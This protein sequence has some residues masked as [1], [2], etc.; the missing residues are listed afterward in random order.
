MKNRLCSRALL[1]LVV[2]ASAGGAL[3]GCGADGLDPQATAVTPSSGELGW[4]SPGTYHRH[5]INRGAKLHTANGIY[6]GPT[7]NIYVASVVERAITELDPRSGRILSQLGPEQGVETPDDLVFGPDGSLYWTAFLTGEVGRLDAAGVKTTVANLGLGVN[8]ITINGDGTKLYVSRVFLGDELW[9]LDLTGMA[10]PRLV[11]SALGG[12]NGMDM[13][14]DGYL[15]GPLWFP[16]MVARVD[17]ATGEVTVIAD[18]FET[19]AAVKFDSRGRLHVVD[20]EGGAVWRVDVATGARELVATVRIGVDNLAFDARDRLYLSNAYDGSVV[21]LLPSGRARRL[22]RGGLAT[23]GGI[24]VARHDGALR[25]F[26]SDTFT[27]RELQPWTGRELDTL[28]GVLGRPGL[29]TPLSAGSIGDDVVVTSWFAHTVQVWDPDTGVFLTTRTD[30]PVPVF[31]T[32]FDG[33]LVVSELSSHCV[34]RIP[35]GSDGKEALACNL[36]VPAGLAGQEGELFVTEWA[37]GSVLELVDGGVTLSP[38][39][40]VVTGLQ[41]PEGIALTPAGKLVVVETGS[42]RL[43]EVD[44]DTG[45]ITVIAEELGVALPAAAGYPPTWIFNGVAVDSCGVIYVTE[46]HASAVTQLVPPPSLDFLLC[47]FGQQL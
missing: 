42:R 10:P 20:Q 13:G 8:A 26:V 28:H 14:P 45:A 6:V 29:A 38:P 2:V 16:R 40:P 3:T 17:V 47:V 15:Y 39:R 35:A 36:P 34:W 37:T 46:D 41:Q 12:F 9:E 5:T 25:L 43:L 33:D 1:C 11:A 18:G 21:R 31:A 44:T 32:G 22:Q 23:P 30:F 7:G 27:L 4:P 24:A 19:L